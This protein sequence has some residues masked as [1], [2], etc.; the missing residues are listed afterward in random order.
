MVKKIIKHDANS[1]GEALVIIEQEMAKNVKKAHFNAGTNIPLSQDKDLFANPSKGEFFANSIYQEG[2]LMLDGQ[3]FSCNLINNEVCPG[4]GN[5]KD[6]G[7]MECKAK[8]I[9]CHFCKKTGH[10]NNS[11]HKMS[12]FAK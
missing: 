4:C 11:W 9:V 12:S 2:E 3:L 5:N 1:L 6:H 8:D 10:F 7:G